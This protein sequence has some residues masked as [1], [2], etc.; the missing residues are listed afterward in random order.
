[1]LKPFCSKG[2][3]RRKLKSPHEIRRYVLEQL[4]TP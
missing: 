3:L 1:M 4:K 2:K